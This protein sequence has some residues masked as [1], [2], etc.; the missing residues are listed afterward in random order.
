LRDQRL[1]ITLA[2]L[3]VLGAVFLTGFTEA[4]LI[5]IPVVAAFLL[6]NAIVVAAA[7]EHIAAVPQS[8]DWWWRALLSSGGGDPVTIATTAVLAFPLL[9]LGLSGFETGVSMMPLVRDRKST[10]LNS[11]HVK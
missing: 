3:A 11:S 7:A 6:L 9:A 10:R 1:L 4:I 8:L 2:L 5:A